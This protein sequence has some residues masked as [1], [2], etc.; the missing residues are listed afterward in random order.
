MEKNKIFYII[1]ITLI[2]I[3]LLVYAIR[4]FAKND[5]EEGVSLTVILVCSIVVYVCEIIGKR[6][7]KD[8]NNK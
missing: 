4:N 3:G 7:H 5:I 6:K 2:S 1:A 8:D